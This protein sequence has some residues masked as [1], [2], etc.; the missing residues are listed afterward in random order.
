MAIG[1]FAFVVYHDVGA[2]RIP[3]GA[4][5]AIA[6]L[7]LV[8]MIVAHQLAPM[9]LTFAV[10]A[11]ILAVAYLLYSISIVGGGDVKLIAATVLL[12]GY[13]DF[14]RFLILMS[15]CGAPL[16]LL[17]VR[18][19]RCRGRRRVSRCLTLPAETAV[20]HLETPPDRS[21]VPYGA[22]IAAAGAMMLIHQTWLLW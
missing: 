4:T 14:S 3:N 15:L 13:D 1:A 17:V 2:R 22:A 20:E 5:L 11:M 9:I 16:A 6:M 12:V 18:G 19:N 21:S 10:A 7:G 8:R